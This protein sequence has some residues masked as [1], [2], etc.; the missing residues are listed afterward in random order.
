MRNGEWWI[1]VEG[2]VLVPLNGVVFMVFMRRDHMNVPLL[3]YSLHC[4]SNLSKSSKFLSYDTF[5]DIFRNGRARIG[6]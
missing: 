2:Q 1:A 5:A 6:P 3:S 4:K